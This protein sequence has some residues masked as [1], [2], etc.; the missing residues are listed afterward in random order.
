MIVLLSCRNKTSVADVTRAVEDRRIA[1]KELFLQVQNELGSDAMN[2]LAAAVKS[3]KDGDIE[4]VKDT[5]VEVLQDQ[6]DL[7]DRFLAFLPK[8]FRGSGPRT[9]DM[10]V[11]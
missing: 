5:F 4:D 2:E 9:S 3:L 6:P 1:A 8:R 7:L 10:H 11:F